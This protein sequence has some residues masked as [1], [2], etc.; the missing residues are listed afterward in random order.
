MIGE[1]L[2]RMKSTAIKDTICLIRLETIRSIILVAVWFLQSQ[3]CIYVLVKGT[4]LMLTANSLANPAQ[5]GKLKTSIETHAPVIE[6]S[7]YL[8]KR[9]VDLQLT[10]LDAIAFLDWLKRPSGE[11]IPENYIGVLKNRNTSVSAIGVAL[12]NLVD[13]WKQNDHVIVYFSGHGDVVTKIVNQPGY[14]LCYDTPASIY[15]SGAH[16]LQMLQGFISSL[17]IENINVEMITEACHPSNFFRDVNRGLQ[18]ATENYPG[19][20]WENCIWYSIDRIK[21]I[22]IT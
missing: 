17:L 8:I 1:E 18:S 16:S 7:D 13:E 15:M 11:M 19:I 12:Y 2:F 3:I 4:T 6:N 20:I 5:S 9:I 21:K 14:L 22:N 10:D